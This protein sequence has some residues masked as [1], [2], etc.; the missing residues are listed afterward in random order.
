MTES[1]EDSMH[2]FLFS[3][4]RPDIFEKTSRHFLKNVPTSFRKHR[5]VFLRDDGKSRIAIV[6]RS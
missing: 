2:W 6:I 4:K 5:D 1:M 3:K